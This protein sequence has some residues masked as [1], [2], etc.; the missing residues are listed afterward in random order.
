MKRYFYILFVGALLSLTSCVQDEIFVDNDN[1]PNQKGG[2]QII[3]AVEEFDEHYVGTRA[4]EVS[5]SYISE[6]TMLIFDNDNNLLPAYEATDMTMERPISSHIHINKPNPTFL[7]E[8]SKYN[9][10]GILASME[11]GITMKYYN[12]KATNI[13]KCKIYI[14]ANAWHLIGPRLENYEIKTL[15]QLENAL[16][17]TDI[18]LQ[19]PVDAESKTIIGLPMIGTHV[20]GTTFNLA[21][22]AADE[23]NAVATIPLKKLYSKIYFRMQVNSN[24]IVSGQTPKFQLEGIEVYNVPK[25][26]RMGYKE[27]QYIDN[28]ANG[29]ISADNINDYY[30]YNS[31]NDTPCSLTLPT[32]TTVYHSSSATTNEY[33]EWSFYVPEHM[34]TSNDISYPTNMPEGLRQY[35]KPKRVGAVNNADGTT[36]LAKIATFV[37][38][39]GSYTDHNAQINNVSYDIYLGQDNWQS[40]EIKRNQQLNNIL[41]ITGITNHKDAYYDT[42]DNVSIDHRVTMTSKGY[43]LSMEREAILDAHFEVRPLD[44]EL[45]P[46]GSMTV[47]IPAEYKAIIA[48]ESDAEAKDDTKTQAEKNLYVNNTTPRKGVRKYFT[49]NLVSDLW[50]ANGGEIKLEHS[51]KDNTKTEIHRIWFYVDENPNVYD[52]KNLGLQKGE[53]GYTV[54]TDLYRLSKVNFYYGNSMSDDENIPDAPNTDATPNA[55]INFQQWNLWRVW[56]ADGNRYYDIEHEEEYLNNYVSDAVYGTFPDGMPWGL[57]GVQLSNNVLAYWSE[58]IIHKSGTI[59]G[60]DIVKWIVGL[61]DDIIGVSSDAASVFANSEQVPYYDFYLSRDNFPVNRMPQE[62][63]ISDYKRDYQG[64]V[65]NEEIAATLKKNYATQQVVHTE[66]WGYLAQIDK[67]YLTQSPSSAFAYCYHKNKRNAEGEVEV[68]KWYL[69]AIDEIEEIALGAYDEF[70]KVFQ[71]KRYWSCQP[72]YDYNK[73]VIKPFRWNDPWIGSAR[74]DDLSEYVTVEGE[75]Y[76]DNLYRARATSV[77]ATSASSY[78]T[79]ES[80]LPDGIMSGTYTANAYGNGGNQDGQIV[81]DYNVNENLNYNSEIFTTGNYRG[82]MSRTESCRIRAVYRSGTK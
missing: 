17:D 5:D 8:T 68:Q 20:A 11:A 65:F 28:V 72:A 6:M 69:P 62:T 19:M 21:Y 56:S 73:I 58:R 9:G 52:K 70:N 36:S 63:I 34:V 67:L 44:V 51:G 46:G 42:P 66:N 81:P 27:G 2:I 71:N 61:L 37:R 82:N 47:V 57:E 10:T 35:Y 24:Q 3:G 54:T 4:D 12:N 41:T 7:I 76:G 79:I 29:S 1:T 32:K 33:L 45:S 78:T 77:Y 80:G 13:S 14:V 64:R 53:S 43:N 39:K 15:E 75:Y 26:I 22:N 49:T 50:K 40:F 31:V 55:T 25:S 30:L 74:Y 23:N 60:I 38:I 59:F 48:M 18:T 16:V